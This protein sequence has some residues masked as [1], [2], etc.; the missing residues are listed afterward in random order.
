[1]M[2]EQ[3]IMMMQSSLASVDVKCSTK[4]TKP[5]LNI[6]KNTHNFNSWNEVQNCQLVPKYLTIAPSIPS[7]ARKIVKFHNRS[8]VFTLEYALS[9]ECGGI[10]KFGM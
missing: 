8:R 7:K 2:N 4:I 9:P 3:I 10:Y 6:D 5:F 1:M